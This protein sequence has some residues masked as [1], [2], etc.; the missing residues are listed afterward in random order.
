MLLK[1]KHTVKV[2]P[3]TVKLSSISHCAYQNAKMIHLRISMF[4]TGPIPQTEWF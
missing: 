3:A 4:L 1:K 2:L